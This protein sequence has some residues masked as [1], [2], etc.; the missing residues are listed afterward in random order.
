MRRT[1]EEKR[2]N[3]IL[4]VQEVDKSFGGLK[5]LNGVS[6]S[7]K[8]GYISALIGPNGAGKTT[9][10][11]LISG[12]EVPDSGTITFL[13][14]D[15]TGSKTW[16]ITRKGICRTFQ[17][18][19]VFQKMTVI[20]NVLTGIHAR[21]TSGWLAGMFHWPWERREERE[22]EK[23][24]ERLLEYFGLTDFAYELAGNIPLIFQRK[25]EI[26]RALA[27]EPKLLLLDEPVAGLNMIETEELGETIK[28]LLS[29]DVSIFLVEHDMNLV[30]SLADWIVVLQHGQKIAEGTPMEVRNNPE[31]ISAYL[32]NE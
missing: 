4:D 29:L 5:A 15:I 2:E 12:M 9:L 6:F 14:N 1:V 31:V 28:N 8:G 20:E 22:M 3:I 21:A 24:A 25:L 23:K 16:E 30:M 7:L 18:G 27:S 17:A 11:N 10:L 19:R 32:G 13:G 26:A